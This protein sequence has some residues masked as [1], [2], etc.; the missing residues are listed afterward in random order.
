MRPMFVSRA[1]RLRRRAG[2]EVM[3]DP[4]QTSGDDALFRKFQAPGDATALRQLQEL[5]FRMS[6][7]ELRRF[8]EGS[9]NALVV[10]Q[11]AFRKRF[12][13][14]YAKWNEQFDR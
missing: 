5:A 13:D 14:A 8:C 6:V 4:I 7:E 9:M 12:P 1:S 3:S 2:G 10:V 11:D